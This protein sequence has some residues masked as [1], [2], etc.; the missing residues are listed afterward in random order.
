MSWNEKHPGLPPPKSIED[1]M[2]FATTVQAQ[3]AKAWAAAVAGEP[4]DS[5]VKFAEKAAEM[6]RDSFQHLME[7]TFNRKS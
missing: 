3:Y 4:T 2:S 7:E 6:T 1:V 5:H